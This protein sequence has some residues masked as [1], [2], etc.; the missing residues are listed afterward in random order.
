MPC[1][2][3]HMEWLF[4]NRRERGRKWG[5][6]GA[7]LWR[8]DQ[9]KR[10]DREGEREMQEAGK[11]HI[12]KWHVENVCRCSLWLQLRTYN[13]RSP[14]TGQYT[15]LWISHSL[16]CLDQGYFIYFTGEPVFS[17]QT[18]CCDF[19]LLLSPFKFSLKCMNCRIIITMRIHKFS[20]LLIWHNGSSAEEIS[21]SLLVI[22]FLHPL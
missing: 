16:R 4:I 19:I 6:G 7:V 22:P 3:V 20:S 15:V 18:L 5:K 12:S 13:V 10:R 14:S 8:Q 2:R 1:N 17:L 21:L 9:W 11:T